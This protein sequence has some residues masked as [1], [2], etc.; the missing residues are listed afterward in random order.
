MRYAIRC[1]GMKNWGGG[2]GAGTD[3]RRVAYPFG[4]Y[5]FQ[6]L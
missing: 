1:L 6:F 2:G 4:G 3:E 5:R